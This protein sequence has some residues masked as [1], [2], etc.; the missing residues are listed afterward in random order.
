MSARVGPLPPSRIHPPGAPRCNDATAHARQHHWTVQDLTGLLTTA[1]C[2]PDARVSGPCEWARALGRLG[3]SG[4]Q[5]TSAAR[6]DERLTSRG[7]H[8][9]LFCLL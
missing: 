2:A 8:F 3:A 7:V 4:Q 9:L 1:L 5:H 6:A